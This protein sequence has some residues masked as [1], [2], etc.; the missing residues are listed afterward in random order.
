[1][2]RKGREGARDDCHQNMTPC[3]Q[4]NCREFLQPF[5]KSCD[6]NWT[7]PLLLFHFPFLFWSYSASYSYSLYCLNSC[8]LPL[9]P[10]IPS[11]HIIPCLPFSFTLFFSYRPSPFPLPSSSSPL[12]SFTFPLPFF[13]LPFYLSLTTSYSLLPLDAQSCPWHLSL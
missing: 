10:S 3:T 13:N 7:F 2:E 9:C 1:M 6:P 4:L 12:P 8:P 5:K 11:T